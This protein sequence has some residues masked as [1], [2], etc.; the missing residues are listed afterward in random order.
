MTT[1]LRVPLP[2]PMSL[3]PRILNVTPPQSRYRVPVLHVTLFRHALNRPQ[4]L[5][6]KD[7]SS[8]LQ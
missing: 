1:S 5:Q 8:P 7:S 2:P 3:T 6:G 4:Q